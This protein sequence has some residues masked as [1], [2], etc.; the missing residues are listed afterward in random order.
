MSDDTT[1][2]E[3]AGAV[4]PADTATV[5]KAPTSDA[6]AAQQPE[7]KA[8]EA[9]KVEEAPKTEDDPEARKKNRTKEYISRINRE[10]AELRQRMADFE[11]R[12]TP[13]KAAAQHNDAPTLEQH[14]F[15]IEQYQRALIEHTLASREAQAKQAESTRQQAEIIASY[16]DKL[17]DF[18]DEH[19]DFQEVVG[20]IAY[21]LNDQVQ[22]AIMAHPQG[23]QIAYHLGTH[24]DD[25]F[26]LAAIQPHLA[27]AAIKR[28]ASRMT[29][30]PQAPHT[31]TPK[32]LTQA[33]A[34]T[35]TVSGRSPTETPA[36]K[37]TDDE[38]YRR[39]AKRRA[40]K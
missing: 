26:Q 27:D 18:A 35:P 37:L 5:A 14:N 31:P 39:E 21:P 28:L 2:P 11:A 6:Q 8:E 10:N 13:T 17:A 33:P 7:P 22:A 29:A 20:S 4:L 38:W 30:A 23:P 15:D 36:E 9:P 3:G 1:L 24:D 25:A 40:A 34:P 19:P 12:Q 16:N 32:P